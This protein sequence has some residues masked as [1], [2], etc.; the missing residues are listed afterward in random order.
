MENNTIADRTVY[1]DRKHE[2]WVAALNILA[3]EF[4]VKVRDP[5]RYS[6]YCDKLNSL[7]D[8][9]LELLCSLLEINN[10]I[11]SLGHMMS[12]N[13]Y[14]SVKDTLFEF[15]DERSVEPDMNLFEVITTQNITEL[16]PGEWIWDSEL[17]ERNAHERSL[18][19]RKI[20][21]PIGFRQI[22]L[23]DLKDAGGY[24]TKPFVLSSSDDN[25][26]DFWTCFVPNQF[27]KFKKEKKDEI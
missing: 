26:Q 5:M 2:G 13:D 6:Y 27:Y 17:I 10:H 14:D 22:R 7:S 19:S 11:T 18:T 12:H 1:S 4:Y 23:L 9:D 3:T 21:E 20:S 16:R 24:Y 8:D 25:V 15:L